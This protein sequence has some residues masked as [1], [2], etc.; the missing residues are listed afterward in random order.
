V[1]LVVIKIKLANQ[2][3]RPP[4]DLQ[5]QPSPAPLITEFRRFIQDNETWEMPFF[6]QIVNAD[7]PEGSTRILEMQ[8]N[9]VTYVVPGLSALDGHNFRVI[10]ELWTWE[11]Q[12]ETLQFGWSSGNERRVAWLQVWFNMTSSARQ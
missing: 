11:P 8:I 6:W 12:S 9:N 5:A 7:M 4:D 10:L 1:Q 2:T 3:I